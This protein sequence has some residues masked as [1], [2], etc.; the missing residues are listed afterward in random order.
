MKSSKFLAKFL[1]ILLVMC[2]VTFL[3]P[4]SGWAKG[5]HRGHNPHGRMGK[6]REWKQEWTQMFKQCF[7]ENGK[8]L[9]DAYE[10]GQLE[11]QKDYCSVE[12]QKKI[13]AEDYWLAVYIAVSKEESH[14][15]PDMPGKNSR[16]TP[17][18][19]FQMN[20]ADMKRHRCKG[21]EPTSPQQAICCAIQIGDNG[22]KKWRKPNGQVQIAKDKEGA[23]GEFFSPIRDGMVGDGRGRLFDNKKKKNRVKAHANR[24]CQMGPGN[25]II[26][27]NIGGT[28][29]CI[30]RLPWV[31]EIL[32]LGG[33]T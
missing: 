9:Q 7:K 28:N 5:K 1:S 16:K 23:L 21:R 12:D 27:D 8:N 2:F 22:T 32:D 31:D 25:L 30:D 3:M 13:K 20:S 10:K 4:E 33:R 11:D 24:L 26:D 6:P 18:G 15:N 14:F 19:L 17:L 29:A